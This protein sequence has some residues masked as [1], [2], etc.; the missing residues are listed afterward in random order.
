MKLRFLPILLMLFLLIGPLSS[1]LR[2]D[3]TKRYD[4]LGVGAVRMVYDQTGSLYYRGTAQ[5]NRVPGSDRTIVFDHG[6]YLVGTIGGE[7]HGKLNHWDSP[8][9]PGPIVNGAPVYRGADSLRFRPYV[10]TN[11]FP[12]AANRDYA[13]WPAD[14]GAPV[15][16][17][18]RPRVFGDETVWMVYNASAVSRID[19]ALHL[20]T[21]KSVFPV[22]IRHSAYGFRNSPQYFLS[23]L[24]DVVLLEW[25]LINKGTEVIDSLYIGFWTDIDFNNADNNLPGVDTTLQLG[26]C[27][28]ADSVYTDRVHPMAVGYTLLF[29]PQVP[30]GSGTADVQEAELPGMRNLPVTS[31]LA[32]DDD[33]YADSSDRGPPKSL[34]TAWN[35]AGGLRQRGGPVI[36][37]TTGL[38]TRF[39]YAGDPVTRTGWIHAPN[40]TSGGAGFILFTGPVTMRPGDGQWLMVALIPALSVDNKAAVTQLR[41]KARLLQELSVRELR[42]SG[43]DWTG[44]S[45]QPEPVPVYHDLRSC[46]PNPFNPVTRIPYDIALESDVRLEIYNTLGQKVRSLVDARMPAGSYTAVFD[47]AGLPSGVYHAVLKVNYLVFH[48]RMVLLK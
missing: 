19:R 26:Y 3:Y 15:D 11:R 13:A 41:Y 39:P 18:G 46:Y 27:W 16:S 32:I 23:F 33:S 40:T 21:T 42:G 37:P 10:L 36:D 24:S 31:F 14:L 6:L 17:L 34:G 35:V 38:P 2:Y 1:Q 45:Q 22:E 44:A 5:W 9:V 48:T 43:F 7:V 8:Y 4:T 30:D 12:P 25:E 29:G 20:D 28:T 47:A